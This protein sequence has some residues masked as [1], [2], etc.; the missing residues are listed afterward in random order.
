MPYV[1]PPPPSAFNTGLDHGDC[2]AP[3]FQLPTRSLTRVESDGS[4]SS[5]HS[6]VK[7]GRTTSAFRGTP[8]ENTVFKSITAAPEFKTLSFEVR[9]ALVSFPTVHFERTIC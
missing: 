9:H 5:G 8:V 1:R 7:P 6:T 3:G 2:A 4:E